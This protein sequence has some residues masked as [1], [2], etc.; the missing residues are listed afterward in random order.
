MV[1]RFYLEETVSQDLNVTVACSPAGLITEEM[2]QPVCRTRV[3]IREYTMDINEVQSFLDGLPRLLTESIDITVSG[4]LTFPLTISDFYGSGNL[5]I[6][7]ETLG[8]CVIQNAV[9]IYNC[10]AKVEFYYLQLEQVG[11]ISADGLLWATKSRYVK[12]VDCTLT[13]CSGALYG[14]GAK[15]GSTMFFCRGAVAG[16]QIAAFAGEA[17]MLYVG[18][19]SGDTPSFHDNDTGAYVWNGGV[20]LLL[21]YAPD[22]LGGIANLKQGG[23]IVK[24]D[25]TLL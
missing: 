15:D 17:S 8:S 25:G 7:G 5:C 12:V 1:L 19:K 24:S 4:T 11:T 18:G 21:D 22:L 20:M 13:G 6:H 16:F 23:M 3:P 2:F 9:S 10:S 14:I